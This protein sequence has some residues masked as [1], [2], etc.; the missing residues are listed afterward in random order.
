MPLD[1]GRP[2]A[3]RANSALHSFGHSSRPA[4]HPVPRSAS[5]FRMRTARLT[6]WLVVTLALGVAG[7]CQTVTPQ[8][9]MALAGP[10]IPGAEYVG[11]EACAE[12]HTQEAKRYRLTTHFG[13]SVQEDEIVTG[14]ACESCHG[15][16]SLHVAGL[17]DPSKIVR[18]SEARCFTCHPSTRAE[19]QLQS[20]HPVPEG[21]MSCS[22]C[23][24]P[25]GPDAAMWSATSLYGPGEQCFECH[26]QFKGPF[27]FE[28]DPI[29]DGCRTCHNSHGSVYDKLL[30]AD[31]RVL[32]IRCHWEPATNTAAGGIGA[33]MHG[34]G[35]PNFDIGRGEEC[36]DCHSAIHGSN[37]ESNL[38]N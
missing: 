34:V 19:F 2:V 28:H 21:W 32:C 24:S 31:E 36:V 9:W 6:P 15:A 35:G 7:A 33:E 17:G 3:G 12:C 30:V 38:L 29:R 1:Q 25:H 18:Y 23:H 16:G 26:K 14:E 5:A 27:V 4:A 22:D 11:M 13:A 8:E 37:L 20:H 10:M